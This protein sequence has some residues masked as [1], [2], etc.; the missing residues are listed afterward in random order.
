MG[1]TKHKDTTRGSTPPPVHGHSFADMLFLLIFCTLCTAVVPCVASH[2]MIVVGRLLL[3]VCSGF[4]L[5]QVA[6]FAKGSTTDSKFT[7][8]TD[9]K[10][11]AASVA[12]Q[13]AAQRLLYP[14]YYKL[15]GMST[16]PAI[17]SV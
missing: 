3:V 15:R 16:W 9:T 17:E 8:D 6:S 4:L 13:E 5:V 12:V 10:H 11:E 7:E 1:H 14:E 2:S